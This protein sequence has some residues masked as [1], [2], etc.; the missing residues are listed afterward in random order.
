MERFGSFEVRWAQGSPTQDVSFVNNR[1]VC[2]PSGNHIIFV[3]IQTKKRSVLTSSKGSI[4]AFAVSGNFE[5]V[6]FSEQR[7]K[8]SIF[9]YTFPELIRRAELKGEVQLDYSLLTFSCSSPYLASYSAVPEFALT[10][11][12]WQDGT[13]LCSQSRVGTEFT[14]LSFNPLNWHQLCLA[15][16][17]SVIL[18]NIERS[19]TQH[20]LK[21]VTVELPSVDGSFFEEDPTSIL[22]TAKLPYYG[23]QMPISAIS[24]LVEKLADTFVPGEVRKPVVRPVSHCWTSTS[25]L[26][27]GCEQG[28]LLNI[29]PETQKVTMLFNPEN[30][31]AGNHP[32]SRL[33]Q[34]SLDT[35]VVHKNGLFVAGNDGV[36]R[37]LSFRSTDLHI[38]EIWSSEEPV[39]K[40]DFSPDYGTLS[41]TTNKGAICVYKLENP[42]GISTIFSV[43][44][45]RFLAVDF[46]APG[47]NYCVTVRDSGEVQAWSVEDG[48]NI[49]TLH[50]HTQAA[51]LACCP[52]S[53]CVAVGTISG[54]VYFV[55]M[56]DVQNP[57]LVHR[58]HLYHIP[59]QHLHYDQEGQFLITGAAD[60]HMFVL[61]AKPSRSF[62]VIGYTVVGCEVITIST[63]NIREEKQVKVLALHLEDSVDAVGQTKLETFGL[64]YEM[65]TSPLYAE[66]CADNRGVLKNFIIQKQRYTVEHTLCSAVLGTSNTIYGYCSQTKYIHKYLISKET[67]ALETLNVEK[68]VKAHQTGP[69]YLCLSPH[70]QWL[71]SVAK[72]GVLQILEAVNMEASAH[73]QCHSSRTGG[74]QSVA[75]SVDGRIIVTVGNSDGTLVCL[76]WR[77]KNTGKSKVDAAV[78]YG[79]S[80]VSLME[81]VIAVENKTL[82]LMPVWI[83]DTE[84]RPGTAE[85]KETQEISEKKMSVEITEQ[86]ESYT[87]TASISPSNSTWLDL[88]LEEAIKEESQ[89]FAN[90]KKD[91]R[92]GI[93]ELR[94][95]IQG[96]IRENESLPDMEKLDQQEFDLDVEE[97]ERLQTEGQ[98]EVAKVRKE[99]EL[100]NLIQRYLRD[101][102]K[103]ECWD[104]MAVKG[105]AVKAFHSDCEVKNYPMKERSQKEMEE[106]ERVIQLRKIETV[107]I[108]TRRELVEILPK[109]LADKEEEE[110]TDEGQK[111]GESPALIGSLSGSFGI[112]SPYLCSQFDLHTKEEKI[113]QILLL[114]DVIY[115][116]K[117]AFNREFEAIYKQK[118]QEISRVRERNQRLQE[119]LAELEIK[120]N[121]WQPHFADSEKPERAL[122]VQDTEIKVEKFISPEQTAKAEEHAKAEEKLR[123][124]TKNDNIRERALGDM[125]GGVLEVK[126]ADALKM[127]I[128]QPDCMSKADSVWTEDDR[129]L[130]KDYE[131][132]IKELNEEREKYKKGLEAEMKKLQT[133]IQETTQSFDDALNRLF[134]RKVKSEMIIY[135]EEMKIASLA[136]SLVVE[137]EL[138]TREAQLNFQLEKIRKQKVQSAEVVQQTKSQVDAYRET[139]DN[140]V[141]ED[142][143]LDRGFRKEFNDVPALLVDQLYKLY[144][145]RPRVQKI[146]TQADNF[147]PFGD[148][149][150]SARA[151]SDAYNQLLRAMDDLDSPENMPETLELPVWER[152]CLARRT[153]LESE[154]QVKHKA[155]TLAEMQ[156][157]LQRRLEED[158]RNRQAMENTLQ[159]L[160]IVREEKMRS[161][162]NLTAQFLLKQGQV[163]VEGGDFVPDYSDSILVYRNVVEDLN[164]TIKSLGEQ[165]IAS[166]VESK[167]FRKGIIQ[168][169]WERKK[170]QMQIEDLHNKA[171]DIQMLRVSKELQKYLFETDHDSRV[172]HEMSVLEQTLAL[173][174]KHHKKNSKNFR[175]VVKELESKIKHMQEQNNKLDEELQELLVSVSERKLVFDAIAVEKNMEANTEQRYQDI[176]QRRKLVDLA[177]SQAQEVAVLRAEVE[178]LRMKTFPALIHK[179][180]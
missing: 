14:S 154:Q 100:E 80:L 126:K 138:N 105:R 18:W 47:Q 50:L 139:Y 92:K 79:H 95:T 33:K 74:I 90:I 86:D 32:G 43:C 68:E 156:A 53:K 16:K 62:S 101:V 91:L 117:T 87:S 21:R 54:H 36:L 59:V 42:G 133:S 142:K 177:K 40:I 60:G 58:I 12:N 129:R 175:R 103:Q 150:G 178:R 124:T 115:N 118:E 38:E 147:H 158:E 167:D 55:D 140:A 20:L 17:N 78:E 168:L 171:R 9:V 51:V 107:D 157:F 166:M 34:G 110:D 137:E 161:Q 83:S 52:S 136:F 149:Q 4:G 85:E 66:Q 29:N 108:N 141:A 159:E 63:L 135:Q 99:I 130:V 104:S 145:R 44:S 123:Q 22:A 132:K 120:E 89:Q 163:E 172:L 96:M 164:A 2:F 65:S 112:A 69:A 41:M 94:K 125:M 121:I 88:K 84:S 28:H 114:K 48:T 131:K 97:Q 109:N 151:A 72:D 13:C 144:K 8:P 116:I 160:N 1:T 82:A 174:E 98:E 6:A 165:K 93:S 170:M 71:A 153:K 15:G 10:I 155:L 146:R 77:H 134:D 3:D 49:S 5:V 179:E 113:N 128:P 81:P 37:R 24:G 67:S 162:L 61:D 70:H 39:I 180:K 35:L 111:Q 152:F 76:T 30:Y 102:I 173:Q 56:T 23:P 106:L 127:D 169:E 75:L 57:R 26:Y 45:G 64:P 176:I 31:T 73:I 46:L 7:L 122:T 19:N 148:H 11:W 27:V 119:I 25:D 143:L